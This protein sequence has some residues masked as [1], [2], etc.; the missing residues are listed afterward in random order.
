MFIPPFSLSQSGIPE[1]QWKSKV[2]E[3]E[4]EKVSVVLEY[5]RERESERESERE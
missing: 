5:D 3:A 1:I 4:G 2:Q